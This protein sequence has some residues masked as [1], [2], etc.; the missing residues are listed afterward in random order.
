MTFN[1]SCSL[2]GIANMLEP[3]GIKKED[4]EIALG[5]KLP[6]LFEYD[7]INMTYKTGISLQGKN[8]FN[9]YLNTLGICF[10]EILCTKQEALQALE[11]AGKP[12]ML[13]ILLE[14][15]RK[16]A[17][18]FTGQRGNKYVFLNNRH[19]NSCEP[20]EYLF[21]KDELAHRL[22]ETV[23]IGLLAPCTPKTAD[24]N[25]ELNN[26]LLVLSQYSNDL[27][28]FCEAEQSVET[29]QASMDR[30]FRPLLLDGLTMMQLIKN[31]KLS[32]LLKDLQSNY[33]IAIKK[34]TSLVLKNEIP[35][36]QIDHAVA[37]YITLIKEQINRKA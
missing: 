14:T 8:L 25:P 20:A 18:I 31:E 30:L 10:E 32:R 29:L 4:H 5:M 2:A 37:D 11:T 36:E 12:A 9:K 22:Q 27:R 3:F 35:T 26:S 21:D 1:S 33:L 6:Y 17:V 28:E 15:D 23:A 13:G 16:H 24:F 7:N 19:E 34:R